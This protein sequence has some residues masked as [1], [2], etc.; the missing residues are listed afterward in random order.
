M[1]IGGTSGP[2]PARRLTF[3]HPMCSAASR[4]NPMDSG[5]AAPPTHRPDIDGLRAVAV[6]AVLVFHAF[7]R[8]LP[9]GFAGVDVFFAISGFLITSLLLRELEDDGI[10]LGDFYAR[11]ARRI[12]PALLVVV[13]ACLGYGWFRMLSDEFALLGRHVAASSVFASNFLLLR[14]CGYFD[15]AAAGKPL[16]HLWSLAVEE[17]FYLV[18]PLF[19]GLAWKTRRPAR[20]VAL[21]AAGSFATNLVLSRT[22]AAAAFYLPLARFWEPALGGLL[23]WRHIRFPSPR[24]RHPEILFGVGLALLAAAF[25]SP[26]LPGAGP[27][28]PSCLA[29]TGTL[30][31]LETAPGSRL[32]RRLLAHRVPTGIGL[33]SYPLYLWH[34]P[35]LVFASLEWGFTGK[36]VRIGILALS[37]LLAWATWRFLEQRIRPRRAVGMAPLLLGVLGILGAT[38]T[39]IAFQRGCEG[40]GIRTPAKSR[41]LRLYE[42]SAPELGYVRRNGL[43]ETFHN[44]CDFYDLESYRRG[45]ATDVPRP[46]LAPSCT[47]RSPGNQAA[48]L[49]WG[50]S[51]AQ[52]LH[53]G[54]RKALPETW[55]IL[56]V[57]SSG[58]DPDP[59]PRGDP[60]LDYCILSNR[61]ALATVRKVRPEV[62]VVAQDKGH[63]PDR[64]TEIVDTL[65][66]FG[67]GRVVVVGPTPHWRTDLPKLV[68][69]HLW[70]SNPERTWYGIDREAI[71]ADSLLR[72][73]IPR[74][75][76]RTYA[77]P[78]SELCDARGC[79]V[80]NGPDPAT[81]LTS[82]DRGHIVPAISERVGR[83]VLAPLILE[84]TTK[85]VIMVR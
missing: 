48:I 40:S 36:L 60:A 67:A 46:H 81:S 59:A 66:A 31:L 55:Q 41:F 71:A 42:N 1:Q 26:L 33:C 29:V 49:L 25:V 5:P 64:L 45:R 3:P 73:R 35:L 72:R 32:A 6:G 75:A 53:P 8:I 18:W 23:A 30:L 68:L 17:Q 22:S 83:E 61:T 7:P 24:H 28:A 27:L 38:G 63:D 74:D 10:R 11:R 79:L 47:E 85:S 43:L 52:Q 62:V 56:Q 50:D 82:W 84:A 20:W 37:L 21:A 13:A 4:A 34:W 15:T 14:E 16:L 39:W 12:L 58:C 80:R 76:R 69:R 51:H 65:L 2:E 77:S 70:E 54:L 9:G 78:L 19:L 57:A 44:E